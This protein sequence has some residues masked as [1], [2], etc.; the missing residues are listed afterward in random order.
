MATKITI[1]MNLMEPGLGIPAMDTLRRWKDEGKIELVEAD[2]AAAVKEQ[3][4]N[5][6]GAPPKREESSE[7]VWKGG[8]G[9]SGKMQESGKA[10]FKSIASILFPGKDPLR[11][12]MGEINGV[13]HLIRHHLIKSEI[14]VTGNAK[15]FIEGG[16]RE[17]LRSHF[18]IVVMTPDEA[19]QMLAEANGWTDGTVGGRKT[20]SSSKPKSR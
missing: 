14:F 18:G 5:W 11:L 16:R 20:S 1:D 6:P 17:V 10:N 2:R 8:R 12:N 4:Y 9:R 13:A 19:V 15:D 7:K 3:P